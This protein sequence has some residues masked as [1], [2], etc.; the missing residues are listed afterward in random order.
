MLCMAFRVREQDN[1]KVGLTRIAPF[2]RVAL[3]ASSRHLF[4]PVGLVYCPAL[5]TAW[6][7]GSSILWK[8]RHG[9]MNSTLGDKLH[10]DVY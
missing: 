5:E 9:H 1:F 3:N 10:T 8:D 4:R 2:Y 6:M 7:R